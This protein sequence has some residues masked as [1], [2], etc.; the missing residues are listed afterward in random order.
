MVKFNSV[1]LTPN[2]YYIYL[3]LYL[4]LITGFL[5]NEDSTGGAFIDYTS[6]KNISQD[7]S[8]NFLTTLLN[9]DQYG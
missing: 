3:F 4:T 9:Y 5:L 2:S 7:F 6:Q 8:N 1:K